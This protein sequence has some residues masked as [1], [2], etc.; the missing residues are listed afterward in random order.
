MIPF[1]SQ[2][3]QPTSC[4]SPL[5]SLVARAPELS[6]TAGKH[7]IHR[8]IKDAVPMTIATT[9]DCQNSRI[10]ST[11]LYSRYSPRSTAMPLRGIDQA[12]LSFISLPLSCSLV[13]ESAEDAPFGRRDW[14]GRSSSNGFFTLAVTDNGTPYLLIDLEVKSAMIHATSVRLSLP[15]QACNFSS[16]D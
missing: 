13:T 11:T 6:Y 7:Q 9:I 14:L 12:K 16:P 10:P 4:L 15:R 3:N 8:S 2:S 1:R 5:D